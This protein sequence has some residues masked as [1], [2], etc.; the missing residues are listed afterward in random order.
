MDDP[1]SLVSLDNSCGAGWLSAHSSYYSPRSRGRR[2]TVEMADL[3]EY[4]LNIFG[5][6]PGE[7]PGLCLTASALALES[8]KFDSTSTSPHLIYHHAPSSAQH[9]AQHASWHPGRVE[10]TNR[11]DDHPKSEPQ[12]LHDPGQSIQFG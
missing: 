3:T 11:N 1:T 2:G 5:G 12:S 10:S 4:F 6:S 8:V 9:R 7:Q